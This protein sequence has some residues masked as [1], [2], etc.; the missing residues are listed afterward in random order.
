VKVSTLVD[1]TEQAR[2]AFT[3]AAVEWAAGGPAQP[4]VNEAANALAAGL[5]TPT[6]RVLAGAPKALADDEARELAPAVFAELGLR[7]AERL[8]PQAIVDGA[9]LDAKRVLATNGSLRKL[10]TRLWHAYTSAGYPEELSQWSGI[11]DWYDMVEQDVTVGSV[12]D[13]DAAALTEARALV[14][15]RTGGDVPLKEFFTQQHTRSDQ[16]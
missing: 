9:R 15:G 14:E 6:L 10:A 3:E 11:D 7:I 13:V 1:S 4:L 12:A 16:P 8:G 2:I 5:D